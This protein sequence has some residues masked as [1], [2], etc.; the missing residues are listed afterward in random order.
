MYINV[1][2]SIICMYRYVVSRILDVFLLDG[3]LLLIFKF[4]VV[5]C[6]QLRSINSLVKK[7]SLSRHLVTT[8]IT[9]INRTGT[10]TWFGY[11]D[12]G[13]VFAHAQELNMCVF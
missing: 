9:F 5:L 1:G 2:V 6:C 10:D 12:T 4:L 7:L 13:L 11:L 3:G 8:Y